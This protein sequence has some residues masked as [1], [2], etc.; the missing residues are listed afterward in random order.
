MKLKSFLLGS[1][2]A[3]M[4]AS[5]ASAADV[6]VED[7]AVEYVRVCEAFGTGY[8][9]IPGTETC[10]K[11]DGELRMEY[12]FFDNNDVNDSNGL[13]SGV[14]E[15]GDILW[16]GRFRVRT[17]QETDLGTIT[18]ESRFESGTSSEPNENF[19][20]TALE[21]M[22][23]GID[24]FSTGFQ[25]YY[26]ARNGVYGLA[27][28]ILD[29]NYGF[30]ESLFAEYTYEVAGFAITAGVEQVANSVLAEYGN[31][32]TPNKDP[33][34]NVNLYAGAN[35]GGTFGFVS[36]TFAYDFVQEAY[37]VSLSANLKPIEG[38]VLEGFFNFGDED[39]IYMVQSRTL[40]LRANNDYAWGVSAQYTFADVTPYILYTD[41]EAG[42]DYISLGAYWKPSG[43]G[44]TLQ[45]E[46][47][48]GEFVA[49]A[50]AAGNPNNIDDFD[51]VQFRLVKSF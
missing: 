16:R 24:G 1:A 38:A 44:L 11:F 50:D 31:V 42:E 49:G 36:G 3:M 4:A 20:P 2:A 46:Y 6:I 29:G 30:D 9:F 28:A 22:V 25:D 21:T 5:T 43:T 13:Q 48:F 35:Y 10:I 15:N 41:S 40:G 34:E 17:A 27:G 8:F 18:T 45:A 39:S 37:A 47:S 51:N 32:P 33:G 23:I 14:E 26:W 7:E 12:G 19:N